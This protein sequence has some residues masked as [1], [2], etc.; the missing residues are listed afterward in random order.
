MSR[1][2]LVRTTTVV[3]LVAVLPF[4]SGCGL[5]FGGS[6]QS[7]RT[8]SS[9]D[10]ATVS[11]T[12]A[13]VEYKTP[14]TLSLERKQATVL[15]FSMDGYTSQKVE[16]QRSMRVGI[17]IADVVLTGLIGVVIDAATGAWYRLSP[18]TATVSLTKVADVSGPATITVTL[19]GDPQ[20][21]G[22][23][24]HVQSTVPGVRVQAQ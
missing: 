12:P 11:L 4:V 8:T 6:R 3:C 7:I 23:G 17:V 22:R 10:N 14:S 15:T 18:E 19:M 16:L 21:N 13:T 24:V 5:V 20:S 9:P 2:V 1:N